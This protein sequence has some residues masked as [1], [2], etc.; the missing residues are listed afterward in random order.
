[1]L[2]LYDYAY[3][4]DTQQDTHPPCGYNP[5]S[6]VAIHTPREQQRYNLGTPYNYST[7]VIV[8][9]V[10][11]KPL[12]VNQSGVVDP[13]CGK[14]HPTEQQKQLR[15][16]LFEDF[17]VFSRFDYLASCQQLHY[18]VISLYRRTMSA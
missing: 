10:R 1:M 15:S 18:S 16:N 14:A 11:T 4:V 3:G 17:P 5:E 13:S 6:R 7:L 2:N 8:P 9:D 12:V